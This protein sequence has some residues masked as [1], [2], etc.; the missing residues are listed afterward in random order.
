M[1]IWG[2]ENLAIIRDTKIGAKIGELKGHSGDISNL[3]FS[4]DGT[5]IVACSN[6]IGMIWDAKTGTKIGE[7]K[8]HSESVWRV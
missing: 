2:V 8:G 4:P 7:L 5:L 3:R 1:V 6:S